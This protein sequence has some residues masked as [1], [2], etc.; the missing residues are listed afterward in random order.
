M[1]DEE[2]G[3]QDSVNSIGSSAIHLSKA[4]DTYIARC[5]DVEK[6]RSENSSQKDLDK[7]TAKMRKSKDEYKTAIEKFNG[8]RDVYEVNL[9]SSCL[10]YGLIH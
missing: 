5:S 9:S 7:A 4:R 1:K 8:F 6:L 3:T 10:R 2:S